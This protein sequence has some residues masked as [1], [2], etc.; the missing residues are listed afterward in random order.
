MRTDA[1]ERYDLEGLWGDA[2][3]VQGEEQTGQDKIDQPSSFQNASEKRKNSERNFQ[4]QN[5][6]LNSINPRH[7]VRPK[8]RGYQS[9]TGFWLSGGFPAASIEA[10]ARRLFARQQTLRLFRRHLSRRI[11]SGFRHF[12]FQRKVFARTDPVLVVWFFAALAE[13]CCA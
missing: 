10:T 9:L 8:V 13:F 11:L 5:E 3:R 6:I 2:A 12:V 4:N 7:P 1:R